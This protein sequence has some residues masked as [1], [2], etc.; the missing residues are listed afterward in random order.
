[1]LREV[2][3]RR[4]CKLL[5]RFDPERDLIEIKTPFGEIETVALDE[6]RPLHLRRAQQVEG[7]NFA[8][9]DGIEAD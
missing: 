1:M 9:I 5:F 6:L 7:V 4:G 8:R 2:R 3:S